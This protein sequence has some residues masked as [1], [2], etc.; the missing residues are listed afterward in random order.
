VPAREAEGRQ[1]DGGFHAWWLGETACL[2]GCQVGVWGVV[3]CVVG[4]E[5]WEKDV[6][7]AMH[8]QVDF[9]R[10]RFR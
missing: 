7:A 2:G 5:R 6:I 1:G 3:I 8:H 10:E 4:G 9:A